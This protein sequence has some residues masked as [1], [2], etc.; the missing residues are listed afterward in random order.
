MS[1]KQYFRHESMV[2]STHRKT[3]A[4]GFDSSMNGGTSRN[5]ARNA[6]FLIQ[7]PVLVARMGGLTPCRL[8]SAVPGLSTRPSRR[9]HLIVGAPASK[10]ELDGCLMTK[11]HET[12]GEA[13]KKRV[14]V[15]SED[16]KSKKAEYDRLRRQGSLEKAKANSAEYYAK[17]KAVIAGKAAK[18]Y[19]ENTEAMRSRINK[20]RINNPDKVKA[21][22]RAWQKRNTEKVQ[23]YM[24]K[25]RAANTELCRA[26]VSEWDRAN[27]PRRRVTAKIWRDNNL[28]KSRGYSHNRRALIKGGKLSSKLHEFLLEKQ[29][30]KC[31]CCRER[32]NGYHLDHIEPLSKGG[33]HTDRNIQLLCP[34][35][36]IRKQNK[37]PIAFMQ[38]RGFLL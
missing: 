26:L 22:T 20:W 33:A 24:R 9:P 17:N 30:N 19:L 29:Q 36:N 31:A 18:R 25:W 3:I 1:E 35:C 8:A 37:D 12:P 34:P 7:P 13:P 2:K 5:S 27:R 15:F 16:Q 23:Q 21:I 38:S 6:A 11:S 4:F 14:R 32:L 10:P 28:S